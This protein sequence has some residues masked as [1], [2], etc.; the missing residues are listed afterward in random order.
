MSF[1]TCP[2]TFV[3]SESPAREPMLEALLAGRAS[4]QAMS[5]VADGCLRK[6]IT[7]LEPALEGMSSQVSG[8]DCL[9]ETLSGLPHNV[10]RIPPYRAS[11]E[12]AMNSVELIS[13]ETSHDIVD[14][15]AAE[16]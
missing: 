10:L 12:S 3:S 8:A 11:W 16:R 5:Q 13:I 4:P 9:Q 14:G 1:K 2:A 7:D 15:I 6:R